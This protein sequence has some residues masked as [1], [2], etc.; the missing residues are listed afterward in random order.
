MELSRRKDEHVRSRKERASIKYA[1]LAGDRHFVTDH[2]R[3]GERVRLKTA[4]V[5]KTADRNRRCVHKHG[6]DRPAMVN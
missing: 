1:A 4:R 2:D 3:S 5:K 6:S